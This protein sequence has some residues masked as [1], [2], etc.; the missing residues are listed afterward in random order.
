M[1]RATDFFTFI[2]VGDYRRL[3]LKISGKKLL[4]RAR[5]YK[6]RSPKRIM[7]N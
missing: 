1:R 3:E 5:L 2:R 4:K 6:K 7:E